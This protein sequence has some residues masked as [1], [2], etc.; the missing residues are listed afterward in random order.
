MAPRSYWIIAEKSYENSLFYNGISAF[1]K[2][3]GKYRR[4]APNI[5]KNRNLGKNRE[6]NGKIGAL[7]SLH[8]VQTE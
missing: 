1:F 7:G 5:G 3:I 8:C 2:N 4:F 6:K